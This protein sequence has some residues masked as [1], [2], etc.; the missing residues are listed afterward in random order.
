MTKTKASKLTRTLTREQQ[1]EE[2]KLLRIEIEYLKSVTPR[3]LYHGAKEPNRNT[4]HPRIN[5]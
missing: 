5:A 1:L 4:N 3:G 2:V